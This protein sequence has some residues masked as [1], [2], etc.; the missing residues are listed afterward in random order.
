MDSGTAFCTFGQYR[1]H[2]VQLHDSTCGNHVNFAYQVSPAFTFKP[3]VP[4]QVAVEQQY[5]QLCEA[6]KAELEEKQRQFEQARAQILEPRYGANLQQGF[7]QPQQ[8][9][10]QQQASVSQ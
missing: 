8:Q 5:Q 4:A 10:Q 9:Q 6:W 2:L 3:L 7:Q 1:C